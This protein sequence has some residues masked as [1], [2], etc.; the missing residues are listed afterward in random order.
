MPFGLKTP[1][2]I[3]KK[4][5]FTSTPAYISV[6]QQNENLPNQ[7]F[8]PILKLHTPDTCR[9]ISSIGTSSDTPDSPSDHGH[10]D[11]PY[12]SIKSVRKNV[13]TKPGKSR[14]VKKYHSES[15][16]VQEFLTN[17]HKQGDDFLSNEEISDIFGQL[18]FRSS[19]ELIKVIL[20]HKEVKTVVE[21][22]L[23]NEITNKL[24]FLKNRKHGKV[25]VLMT[26]DYE[27]LKN[28]SWKDLLEE[29]KSECPFLLRVFLAVLV[30]GGMK[31]E[32]KLTKMAG[33]VPRLGMAYAILAQGRN[34]LLSKVQ[35]VVSTI[36]FD[37]ICD[38]K[39]IITLTV[40]WYSISAF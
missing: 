16:Y 34:A 27:D 38:Q 5:Q 13:K 7:D 18:P 25:S 23:I 28:F 33:N 15:D 30:P 32:Q 8:S 29:L 19:S 24:D 6:E 9:L 2:S 20:Q 4:T 10:N 39:V 31:E 14:L 11:H 37:N 3:K 1:I 21:D 12:T 26:K 36:L 22:Y 35:R 40:L 17:Q